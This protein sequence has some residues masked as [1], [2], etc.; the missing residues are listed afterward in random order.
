MA[1]IEQFDKMASGYQTDQRLKLFE[2]FKAEVIASGCHGSLLDFGAG[3]GNLGIS[4]AGKFESVDLLEPAEAM[5]TVIATKLESQKLSNCRILNINL[6]ENSHLD[7]QYDMIVLAQVLLHIPD[8]L[9]VI[10]KLSANLK[11]QGK[12]LIFDYYLNPS[13]THPQVHNGFEIENLSDELRLKGFKAVTHRQ[14]Y[15]DERLL[16]GGQGKLFYLEAIKN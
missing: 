14:I 15:E 6:E 3:T 2:L 11:P 5:Q 12:L 4:L 13:V 7:H 1:N 10:D 16:L 9:A 8:Y